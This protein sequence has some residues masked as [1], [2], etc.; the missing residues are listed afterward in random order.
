M[1]ATI[2]YTYRSTGGTYYLRYVFPTSI[3]QIFPRLGRELR[4]SLRSKH[5]PEARQNAFCQIYLI[6]Q[7]M[8]RLTEYAEKLKSGFDMSFMVYISGGEEPEKPI[9]SDTCPTSRLQQ[10]SKA[11]CYAYSGPK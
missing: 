5:G 9:Q 6:N 4:Y 7:A 11:E 8:L 2:P 3:R 1:A 10:I